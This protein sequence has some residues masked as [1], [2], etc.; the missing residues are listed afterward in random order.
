MAIAFHWL[1]NDSQGLP[2]H[3]K[4]KKITWNIIIKNHA[5]I[6]IYNKDGI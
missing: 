1:K 6:Q 5:F 3:E 4:K 2:L